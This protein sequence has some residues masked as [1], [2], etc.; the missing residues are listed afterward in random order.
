MNKIELDRYNKR[1]KCRND[2]I[3]KF[4]VARASD[5]IGGV[6]GVIFLS[7]DEVI[8]RV[9]GKRCPYSKR[10]ISQQMIGLGFQSRHKRIVNKITGK[11]LLGN[12]YS[13]TD[14]SDKIIKVW[15][16]CYAS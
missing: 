11:D 5:K 1:T 14:G 13:M 12:T 6:G 4:R 15:I 10:F 7:L 16:V 3:A 9:W 2:I 8:R